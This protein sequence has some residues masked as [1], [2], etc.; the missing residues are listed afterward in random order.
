MKIYTVQFWVEY[1]GAQ[2]VLYA[3]LDK[4]QAKEWVKNQEPDDF[5]EFEVAEVELDVPE[6]TSIQGGLQELLNMLQKDQHPKMDGSH[7]YSFRR[8]R[9]I[10]LGLR[11][12]FKKLPK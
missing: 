5:G 1:E 7:H 2:G 10:I 12:A 9:E 4:D 6:L 11:A 3:C 8:A